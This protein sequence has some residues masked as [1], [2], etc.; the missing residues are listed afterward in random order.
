MSEAPKTI[1]V[2]CTIYNEEAALP[3]FFE[4]I[5]AVRLT[6]TDVNL[7]LFFI[8]NGSWDRSH[9]IVTDF[10][11]EH[12]WVFTFALSRNFGYQGALMCGFREVEADG[13]IVIDVDCEDPPEMLTTFLP[14]WL[15]GI[16]V[17]YGERHNRPE[18]QALKLARRAFYRLTKF[19]ADADFIL[20]MAEFALISK[21]V[22]DVVVANRSTSPFVRNEIAYSGYS[23]LAVPY[24]R[25]LRVA[26]KTHYRIVGMS[27]F[28]I[29]GIFTSS[30]FLLRV[31]GYIVPILVMFNLVGLIALFYTPAVGMALAVV[32]T[33]VIAAIAMSVSLYIARIYKDSVGRPIYIVDELK[34]V[35]PPGPQ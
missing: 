20:D 28:A 13:Y 33:T 34:S 17:V 27:K 15:G 12:D 14:K 6:V 3:I 29:S 23:R 1:A 30:T 26:G 19:I 5:K 21:R 10:S 35:R 16:D 8:E 7:K 22:R 32:N 24:D 31:W 9:E 25:Q 4:R 11:A 2:I 18:A